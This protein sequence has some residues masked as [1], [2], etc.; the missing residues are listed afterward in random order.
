MSNRMKIA[1]RPSSAPMLIQ[2]HAYVGET[3]D[4]RD[5]TTG[6]HMHAYTESC[7][8]GV[9][10]DGYDKAKE[11]LSRYDKD[12]CEATADD[13]REL[14]IEKCGQGGKTV[15]E[16]QVSVCDVRGTLITEGT[17]DIFASSK[18]TDRHVLIDLKGGLDFDPDRHDY[19]PQLSCYAMAKMQ[20]IKLP[21]LDVV[22][23]Y[24]KSRMI[25]SYTLEWKEASAIVTAVHK[26]ATQKYKM[27]TICDFCHWCANQLTCPVVN[28]KRAMLDQRLSNLPEDPNFY[29][30]ILDP[31][32]L[33]GD[34]EHAM[35]MNY[36][37]YVL[38]PLKKKLTDIDKKVKDKCK[39]FT[40]NDQIPGWQVKKRASGKT[41][42]VDIPGAM[43]RTGM[44]QNL[45]IQAVD[46]SIPKLGECYAEHTGMSA[47]SAK[48]AVKGLLKDFIKPADPTILLVPDD[49][50]VRG[51]F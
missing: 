18:K 25:K 12:D 10:L 23:A 31:E 7:I 27:P 44:P 30:K 38:N 6:T 41:I 26:A 15:F 33:K 51:S 43:Q 37:H 20:E 16:Q 48:K 1:F 42:I 47:S 14:I 2:C 32:A 19:R 22:E 46:V 5:T 21:K 11:A 13:L 28:A 4:T 17:C 8:A 34:N 39:S 50:T 9:H 24:I 35:A 36:L 49:T 29:E 40:E 45:W 3:G